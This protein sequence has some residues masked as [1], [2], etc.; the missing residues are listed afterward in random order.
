MKSM[1][2]KKPLELVKKKRDGHRMRSGLCTMYTHT[3]TVP[4]DMV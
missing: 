4:W 1:G 3:Y 2:N